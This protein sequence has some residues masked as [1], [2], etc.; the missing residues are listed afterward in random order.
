[1][2]PAP[3]TVERHSISVEQYDQ[4]TAAYRVAAERLRQ[5]AKQYSLVVEGPRPEE[6]EQAEAALK[7]ARQ[8]YELV[9]E[10]PRRETD[11]PGRRQGSPGRGVAAA[12][13]DALG[14]AKVY[15]PLGGV[16]LSKNIEPGEV[17][18]AGTPVVTAVGRTL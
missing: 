5:V 12:G 10:G 16:V 9:K 7:Q 8:Q 15:S 17:V 4:A 3:R 14:Y 2:G 13:R 1:L 11:R 18:A 6:I